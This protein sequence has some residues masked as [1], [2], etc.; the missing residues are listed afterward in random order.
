MKIVSLKAE[1][2]KRLKA[3]EITPDGN[4]VIISGRN[5][6]GKTSVL[7][8]IWMAL[9]GGEAQK[10]TVRPIRDGEEKASITLD[11][12]EYVVTRNWTANDKSYLKVENAQGASFKSPQA[13]LDGLIGKMSFDPL[14]FSRLKGKEQVDS[15][16]N[17][18]GNADQLLQLDRQRDSLYSERTD[19]NRDIKRAQSLL[20]QSQAP[21]PDLPTEEVSPATVF[22]EMQEAQAKIDANRKCR[23][24]LRQAKEHAGRAQIEVAEAVAYIASLEKQLKTAKAALITAEKEAAT[25]Q[26]RVTKGI[27]VVDKLQDPD[28]SVFQSK[29]KE[30]EQTNQA[31]RV[32]QKYQATQAERDAL[33]S[34]ADDLTVRIDGITGAKL[35]ALQAAK[36]PVPE[37]GFDDSG[38]TLSGVPF[39]QCSSAEQLKVSVAMAMALNPELRVIRILDGS[40]L[41]KES[42]AVIEGLAKD[43]DYQVWIE[44]VDDTGTVG[45]YIEDGAIKA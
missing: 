24:A 37:L 29:L 7:D 6:Q 45:V 15:L 14:E 17:V 10:G 18:I 26:A 9:G 33:K 16:L 2:V 11:L 23:E 22:A 40:L 32:A 20:D 21:S 4:T 13:I 27:A 31:I 28:L 25:A 12:G 35:S 34:K 38:V 39:R 1:N 41:D 3:I 44:V 19:V 8:A 42:M 5:G 43:N 36:F 30:V